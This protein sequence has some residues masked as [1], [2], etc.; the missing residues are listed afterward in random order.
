MTVQDENIVELFFDV[1]K[2]NRS[3]SDHKFGNK[4]PF[5]GQYQ[6]LLTLES[7][8]KMTQKEIGERLGIRPSSVSENLTKLEQKGLIIRSV[9]DRDKRVSFV[10]LTLE[11]QREA[12]AIRKKKALVHVDMLSYLTE[13]EKLQFANALLKI[14]EFYLEMGETEFE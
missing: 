3:Y 6:C 4:I 5:R 9:S 12:E 7:H 11:G 14:K 2:L 8:G 1:S 10:S 13:T